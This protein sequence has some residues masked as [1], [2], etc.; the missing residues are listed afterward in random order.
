MKDCK[1]YLVRHGESVANRDNIVGGHFDSPLTK[2]GEGQTLKTKKLLGDIHFDD[3]YSSDLQRASETG[4]IIYG[5]DI[6]ADHQLFDLRERNFGRL[7]GKSNDEWHQLNQEYEQKYA[8]LS[9]EERAKYNYADFIESD[10]SVGI[11]FMKA[12]REIAQTHRG[13]AVLI[14]THG[15]D[16]RVILMKLGYAQFLTAGSFANA[17]YV[18]LTCDGRDFRIQKVVGVQTSGLGAE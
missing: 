2:K 7:E 6:P 8:Q 10:E 18:E 3:A 14:A 13:K 5:K 11:R 1:L 4:K 17:G 9:F 16:I 12:L 15:G